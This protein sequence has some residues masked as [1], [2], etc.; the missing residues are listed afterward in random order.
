M[1]HVLREIDSFFTIGRN[2]ATRSAQSFARQFGSPFF[3]AAPVRTRAN[4]IP[5]KWSEEAVAFSVAPIVRGPQPDR[6]FKGVADA[7]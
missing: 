6:E 1:L 4:Q 2:R 5:I 3:I 7:K